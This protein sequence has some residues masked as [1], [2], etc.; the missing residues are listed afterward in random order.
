MIY[1]RMADENVGN[2]IQ[3]NGGKGMDIS[4]IKEQGTP[5]PDDLYLYT[6][7][8][9]GAVQKLMMKSWLHFRKDVL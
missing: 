3:R 9:E 5:F 8:S 4:E 7:V 6:G 1:V 2:T